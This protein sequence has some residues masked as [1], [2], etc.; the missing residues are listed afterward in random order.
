[1]HFEFSGNGMGMES[2]MSD[3]ELIPC[4]FC[5]SYP[6]IWEYENKTHISCCNEY[7]VS[8]DGASIIHSIRIIGK[9]RDAVIKEWN[10]AMR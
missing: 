2:R 4:A 6:D 10:E 5:N 8:D 3:T 9:D 1:M 7:L